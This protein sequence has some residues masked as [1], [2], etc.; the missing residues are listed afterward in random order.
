MKNLLLFSEYLKETHGR[1]MQRVPIDL[2]LS[3]PHRDQ[4]TG[5][6]GCL[7]CAEDGARARHL[8]KQLSIEEQVHAGV[9]YVRRRYGNDV[10][11]IAYFQAFTST[12]ASPEVVRALF[13]RTLA[14]ARFNMVVVAT[15]PDALPEKTVDY[16][17]ELND[18]LPLWVELGVQTANN[19]TLQAMNRGH[20]FTAVTDAC[21]RLDA[22]GIKTAAHVILGLPDEGPDDYHH[23][24]DR[25]A[26]LPFAAIK[27]H[28]LLVLKG[29]PLAAAYDR[30]EFTVMNEYE[31]A[32]VLLDFTA[33]LPDDWP[34]MRITA[35]A[36]PETILAP[37]WRMK[38]GQ[39]LEFVKHRA[40]DRGEG[41]AGNQT[42]ITE[43]GSRT[44]YH[45]VFKEHYHCLAG[46]RSEARKKF[47][48]PCPF[49][50]NGSFRLLDVGF[51]LGYNAIET[52]R[53]TM[54]NGMKADI[55]SLERE[56]NALTLALA[57]RSPSDVLDNAILNELRTSRTWA[58]DNASIHL[59]ID[60]A[61]TAVRRISQE[62]PPFDVIFLDAFS[63]DK[64]PELWTYDF[65]REL[66]ESL[67]PDGALL[68]Y[69]SA[70]SF[71]GALVRAGFTVGDTPPF[72]RRR[73]GTIASPN[74]GKITSPL[75]TKDMG[76]ITQSTA[77]LPYRDPP[78]NWPPEKIREFRE[79]VMRRLR[80]R[81]IPKWFSAL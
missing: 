21:R 15:R 37:K 54:E 64:N 63:T 24:A 42:V 55:V 71:R 1:L 6:G 61:R 20:D 18:S 60:D 25:L 70:F 79:K 44:A 33:R 49:P 5:A 36:A 9:N 47:I 12:N 81:G 45:P 72:G 10:G 11:L 65:I 69:S 66:R 51:G 28:N 39:F 27:I 77:G 58:N 19:A 41:N 34:L 29:T 56:S 2:G 8:R 46:A 52:I 62:A 67:S 31:Y 13:D 76:I 53:F 35:D 57:T 14:M 17:A 59:I 75:K 22:A 80:S 40:R 43:D 68:S 26:N 48:A 23:T 30:G 78:L 3:C 50:K 73:P 16:L 74:P 38:K 32:D 4:R 7:F